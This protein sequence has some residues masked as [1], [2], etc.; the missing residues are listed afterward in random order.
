VNLTLSAINVNSLNV[1]T[2]KETGCKTL[3]KLVAI[4]DKGCDIILIT[5]CRLGKG[6]E[7]IRKALLV[8]GSVSY[9]LI[10]NS[11]KG[12]RGVCI[13][14]NRNRDIE[15]IETIRDTVTEN[16]LL[17]RCK[18]D[19]YEMLIGGVYGPNTNNRGFYSIGI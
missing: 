8:G 2:Y 9:S 19:G 7:K 17:I 15:I 12:E 14:I 5:D 18:V 6:I 10:S 13:A 1:S 11:T 3:E 16:Y 4:T